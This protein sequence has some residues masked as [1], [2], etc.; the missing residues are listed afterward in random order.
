M[1]VPAIISCNSIWFHDVYFGENRKSAVGMWFW[2]NSTKVT[3][4][5]MPPAWDANLRNL[6]IRVHLQNLV[7]VR[8][9]KPGTFAKRFF[10]PML[11]QEPRSL[12]FWN[13]EDSGEQHYFE[14]WK[15]LLYSDFHL[16]SN[17]KSPSIFCPRLL[18]VFYQ[19]S[20]TVAQHH[21]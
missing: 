5:I 16:Y 9:F 14:N 13:R 17:L 2:F 15:S 1:L 21:L 4:N 10:T 20:P 18:Q 3:V 11:F 7:W 8:R 12:M 19:D 6:Y